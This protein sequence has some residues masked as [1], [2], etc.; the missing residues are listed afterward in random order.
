MELRE[1]ERSASHQA[2][3][4]LALYGDTWVWVAFAPARRLAVAFVG[5][6][7]IKRLLAMSSLEINEQRVKAIQ[8]LKDLVFSFRYYV[9]AFSFSTKPAISRASQ[10]PRAE[11]KKS[12][13]ERNR[14]PLLGIIRCETIFRRQKNKARSKG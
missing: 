14:V 5:A 10:K 9:E 8:L 13:V 1:Q 4:V 2:E 11:A 7:A 12:C 6:N 3:K